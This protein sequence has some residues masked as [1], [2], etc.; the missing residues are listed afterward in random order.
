[1]PELQYFHDADPTVCIQPDPYRL[2]RFA[3]W[4]RLIDLRRLRKLAEADNAQLPKEAGQATAR[5]ATITG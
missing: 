5:A 1:M 4:L 3:E 2:G